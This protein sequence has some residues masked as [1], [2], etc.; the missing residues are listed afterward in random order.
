VKKQIRFVSP[1]GDFEYETEQFRISTSIQPDQADALICRWAPTPELLSFDGPSVWYT[2]EPRT[3]PRI[4]VLAH[5]DQRRFLRQL[6]PEQILHHAHNDP[7]FRVPHV[8]HDRMYSPRSDGPRERRAVAVVSNFG[9]AISNRGPDVRLRNDFATAG[10]VDLYGRPGKWKLYRR[11]VLAW[12]RRP[13]N[14]R[15]SIDQG[16]ERFGL[17]TS[18]GSGD[19]YD[20]YAGKIAL[21]A[22]YHAAVCLENTREP[23]YFTEKFVQAAQAGCVPIYQAHSTVRD[24]VLSGAEWVDPADFD[25]DVSATVAHALSLDR[26]E[27]AQRNAVWLTSEGVKATSESRVWDRIGEFLVTRLGAG[28]R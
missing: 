12:P 14:F 28:S 26:E 20:S 27:V 23:W 6:G 7:R 2:C 17:T 22:R 25:M 4:G 10:D 9:G 5:A 15:G 16:L 1:W 19:T 24:S 21:T 3:N 8:T 18:P 11:R 13:R